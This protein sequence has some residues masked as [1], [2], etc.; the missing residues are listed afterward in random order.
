MQAGANYFVLFQLVKNLLISQFMNV[1]KDYR[2]RNW[3]EGER[4]EGN[5]R[6]NQS[7]W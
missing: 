1:F 4:V 7:L 5:N 3:G 6:K 2:E